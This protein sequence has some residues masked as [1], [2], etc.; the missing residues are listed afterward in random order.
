M[1]RQSILNALGMDRRPSVLEIGVGSGSLGRPF[2]V[3]GDDYVGTDRSY[4]R[5]QAVRQSK[6]IGMLARLVQASCMHLPFQDGLFDAVLLT[7]SLDGLN[8]WQRPLIEICR[9]VRSE[10]AVVIGWTVGTTSATAPAQHSGCEF[11][12]TRRR[13]RSLMM[14]HDIERWL[15][16]N[17]KTQM[18]FIGAVWHAVRPGSHFFELR[19]GS[20]E[21]YQY[22]VQMYRFR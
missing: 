22:V 3:M 1:V 21:R 9:V 19:S 6:G 20:L 16:A 17:A 10:S 5:L 14:R 2:I 4:E 11:N 13:Q 12:A 8:D 15:A 7:D 18:R